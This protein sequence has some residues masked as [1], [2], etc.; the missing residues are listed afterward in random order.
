MANIPLTTDSDNVTVDLGQIQFDRSITPG[1]VPLAAAVKEGAL[2]IN[3]VDRKIFTKDQDGNIISLGRDY[4]ADITA[5]AAAAV[6]SA[7]GYT[8]GLISA[9]KGGD[10]DAN[11]DTLLKLGNRLA[12]AEA[13]I[14]AGS[15]AV[16][17]LTSADVGL[18]NVGNFGISDAI[19]EANASQYASSAAVKTAFDRAVSGEAAAIAYADQ[20][21]SDLLGGA[22][23]AALDTLVELGTALSGNSDAIAAITTELAT[24]ATITALTDGLAL[25]VNITDISDSIVSDSSLQVAS[26]KAVK[27]AVTA[28]AAAS[29]AGLELKVDKTAISSATASDS[30]VQVASSKAVNDSR[31][32]AIAHANNLVVGLAANLN[33]GITF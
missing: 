28:A 15:E 21:K 29:E 23:A 22:P 1:A 33:Y 24:K 18:G 5:S 9:V 30:E 25:K 7:N 19:D 12:T 31:L 17:D 3:L 26:S 8:D 32:E 13:N 27:D 20:V 4:S 14:V 11:L 16:T 10:L 2:A 6:S